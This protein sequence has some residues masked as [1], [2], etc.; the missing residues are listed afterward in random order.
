MSMQ[1]QALDA[2]FVKCYNVWRYDQARD[3]GCFQEGGQDPSRCHRLKGGGRFVNF[4]EAARVT[5][6]F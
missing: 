3:N 1:S 4:M 6:R 5:R 2:G